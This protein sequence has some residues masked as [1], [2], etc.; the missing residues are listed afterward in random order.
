MSTIRNEEKA[1][2]KRNLRQQRSTRR[3][4]DANTAYADGMDD[5]FDTTATT[6]MEFE[7]KTT[8]EFIPDENGIVWDT[9]NGDKDELR[10]CDPLGKTEDWHEGY[11]CGFGG[12]HIEWYNLAYYSLDFQKGYETGRTQIE[13]LMD[14]YSET[15]AY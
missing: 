12:E 6:V 10:R 5:L 7:N 14:E 2:Q 4:A 11:N 15:H 3:N 9:S 8:V 13:E 1:I